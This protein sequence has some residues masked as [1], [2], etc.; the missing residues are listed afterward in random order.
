MME[1]TA[2]YLSEKD[3]PDVSSQATTKEL[4]TILV[5]ELAGHAA[6][7]EQMEI[8]LAELDFYHFRNHYAA[9]RQA[10]QLEAAKPQLGT[11]QRIYNLRRAISIGFEKWKDEDPEKTVEALEYLKAYHQFLDE[12]EDST[13]CT[14]KFWSTVAEDTPSS[15]RLNELGKLLFECKYKAMRTVEKLNRLSSNNLEFLVRY[16]LFMR[17]VMHD[18]ITSEQVF[19]KIVSLHSALASTP[20]DKMAD[21]DFSIFRFDSSVM[22]I[23]ARMEHTGAAIITETNSVVEQVLGYGQKEL[24]GCSVNILMPPTVA[25][26]HEEYVRTFFQSMKAHNIDTPRARYVRTKEGMY[27]LCRCLLKVVPRLD[28]TLQTAMFMVP[29]KRYGCYTSFRRETTEKRAGSVL[30]VP[31]TYSIMGF[32][33]EAIDILRVSGERIKD[34]IGTISVYDIFPWMEHKHLMEQLFANEGKVVEYR[35]TNVLAMNKETEG[36]DSATEDRTLLWARFIVEKAD[37][38]SILIALVI[39]EIP[40]DRHADYEPD[41]KSPVFYFDAKKKAVSKYALYSTIPINS[42]PAALSKRHTQKTP[43]EFRVSDVASVASITSVG[44]S[45]SSGV[46][47]SH[48]GYE[49]VRDLQIASISKQTPAAIKWLSVGMFALLVVVATLIFVNAFVELNELSDLKTRFTL[50]KE[51]HLRYKAAMVSTEMARSFYVYITSVT[52]MTVLGNA[53]IRNDAMGDYNVATKKLLMSA[54]LYYDD[55]TID[56]TDESN[57]PIRVSFSHAVLIVRSLV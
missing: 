1:N 44:V 28:E 5:S 56:T 37:S 57:I 21:G 22:L 27:V 41:K 38:D 46:S 2:V 23:A 39:S 52:V 20:G 17:L 30:F 16:G 55:E 51:Y 40:R 36:E 48:A 47:R 7:A 4:L 26:R 43:K 42:P 53:I 10:A 13:E 15:N 50:I 32:T 11:V 18:L 8:Q 45:S 24:V 9:L 14:I 34:L 33:R 25:Q 19:Q 54:K 31:G 35:H 29:D 12:V 49:I 6:R 3:L